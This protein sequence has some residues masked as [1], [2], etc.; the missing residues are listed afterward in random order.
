MEKQYEG[1]E[2]YKPSMFLTNFGAT[3][4]MWLEIN[5]YWNQNTTY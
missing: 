5:N 3:Q 4:I 2:R 1:I